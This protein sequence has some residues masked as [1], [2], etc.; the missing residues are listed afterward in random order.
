MPIQRSAAAFLTAQSLRHALRGANPYPAL[1][2]CIR[3]RGMASSIDTGVIHRDLFLVTARKGWDQLFHHEGHEE[4]EGN[5]CKKRFPGLNPIES[6][7][8]ELQTARLFRVQ[9]FVCIMLLTS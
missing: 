2:A 3:Y 6:Y 8:L 4:H 5:R 1:P 7:A 9:L